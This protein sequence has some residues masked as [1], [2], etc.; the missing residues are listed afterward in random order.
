MTNTPRRPRTPRS[1]LQVRAQIKKLNNRK[2]AALLKINLVE[3]LARM[4][5]NTQLESKIKNIRNRYGLK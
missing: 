4:S 2:K 1:I 5:G 3:A